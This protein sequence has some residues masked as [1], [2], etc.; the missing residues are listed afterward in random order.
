MLHIT[1]S[2]TSRDNAYPNAVYFRGRM[3]AD[4]VSDEQAKRL[5]REVPVKALREALSAYETLREHARATMTDE[6][7]DAQDR[8]YERLTIAAYALGYRGEPRGVVAWAKA[9]LEGA[10]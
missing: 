7:L 3:V 1:P 5:L 2:P 10:R 9:Y 6:A 8:A 4:C